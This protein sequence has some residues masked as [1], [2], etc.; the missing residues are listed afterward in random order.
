MAAQAAL[1]RAGH[2]EEQEVAAA[3]A[4]RSSILMS[5]AWRVRH[6]ADRPEP[7]ALGRLE[8]LATT[9]PAGLTRPCREV[10]K[11]N[12]PFTAPA[13]SPPTSCFCNAKNNAI[14]GME[15]RMAPAAKSPH[16]VLLAPTYWASTTG[17]V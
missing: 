8:P 17:N 10:L 1:Q 11:R 16:A 6:W 13:V 2:P 9:C 12:Q 4:M 14:T 7:T 15:T 5:T 3:V